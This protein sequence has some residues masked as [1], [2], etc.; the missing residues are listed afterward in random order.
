MGREIIG[1]CSPSGEDPQFDRLEE[2]LTIEYIK[3]QCGEPPKGVSIRRTWQDH[4]LGSYPVISVVWDDYTAE[5]P[6]E[7]IGKCIDAFERF[8]FPEEI[9]EKW[10]RLGDLQKDIHNL[11]GELIEALKV[12]RRRASRKSSTISRTPL[13][14]LTPA[15]RKFQ[16]SLSN[17]LKALMEHTKSLLNDPKQ[18]PI[19]PSSKPS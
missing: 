11:Y 13:P 1:E 19:P 16:R 10:R 2:E 7:Y 17:L 5:Y 3:R 12:R 9:Y 18:K 8:E 14:A 4:D 15:Q 6:D